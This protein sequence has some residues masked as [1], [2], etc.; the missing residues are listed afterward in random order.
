VRRALVD[1]LVVL[2]LVLAVA[3][4]YR[5]VTRLWWIWDDA[6]LLH[7]AVAHP[8]LD[9]FVDRSL[10]LSMPQQLFTPL[11]TASYDAELALFGPNPRS[12]YLVHLIELSVTAIALYFTLRFWISRAAAACAALLFLIGTPVG[13]MATQLVLKHYIESVI[14]SMGSVALFTV[15]MRRGRELPGILSGFLYLAAMLAKEI[16][17]PLPV[18]LLILPERNLRARLRALWPRDRAAGL[19]HVAIFRAGKDTGWLR[20]D[21]RSA[22]G[23]AVDRPD[24]GT[25]RAHLRRAAARRGRCLSD[26][27]GVRDC[28]AAALS[29]RRARRGA[30][31]CRGDRA[32]L[33]RRHAV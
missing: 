7:I 1:A 12:F 31:V 25:R 14:L 21:D 23:A 19:L 28:V 26:P 9:H 17:V 15:A 33:S 32:D 20:L 11:L 6:Y 4:L 16:A 3:L 30:R 13:V 24:A 29:I 5:K 27:R 18:V 2:G 8:V 10:W 22:R